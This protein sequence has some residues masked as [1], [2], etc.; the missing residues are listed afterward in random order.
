VLVEKLSLP[1]AVS[2]RSGQIGLIGPA[3]QREDVAA[4]VTTRFRW[5]D[6]LAVRWLI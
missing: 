2:A 4:A 5:D 1:S 6:G 3:R